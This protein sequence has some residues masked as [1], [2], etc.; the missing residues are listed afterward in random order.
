MPFSEISALFFMPTSP[1]NVTTILAFV[2]IIAVLL[3]FLEFYDFGKNLIYCL[4][5]PVSKTDTNGIILYVLS[6]TDNFC[7]SF[8]FWDS[9]MLMYVVVHLFFNIL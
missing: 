5:W 2:I 4:V 1:P 7:L 9:F 3:C 6:L 8:C